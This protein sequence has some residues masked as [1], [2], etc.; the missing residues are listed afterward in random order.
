MATLITCTV[1]P[2]GTGDYDTLFAAIADNFGATSK[3]LVTNDE[4]VKCT[5]ISTNGD[6]DPGAT[7][8][9][10]LSGWSTDATHGVEIE[11][12]EAYR[13]PGVFPETGPY[14]RIDVTGWRGIRVESAYVTIKGLYIRVQISAAFNNYTNGCCLFIKT[15]TGGVRVEDAVYDIHRLDV[16]T[17]PTYGFSGI[18]VEG[19]T[20]SPALYNEFSNIAIRSSQPAAHICQSKGINVNAGIYSMYN[21]FYNVTVVDFWNNWDFSQGSWVLKNILTF[22][23]RSGAVDADYRSDLPAY[24]SGAY[25]SYTQGCNPIT[26]DSNPINLGSDGTAIFLDYTG[27]DLHLKNS[28]SPAYRVG[29]NL[30]SDSDLPITTDFEGDARPASGA[31]SIGA[32]EITA[33][34]SSSTWKGISM[35]FEE[36][37]TEVRHI[38]GRND[39][40]FDHRIGNA[41][42]RAIREWVREFPWQG[43]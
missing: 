24:V 9:L 11:V 35:D 40:M 8:G 14:F 31:H 38:T 29:A 34:V 19:A 25:C 2:G 42:N 15:A 41:V 30:Y 23:G 26:T 10:I 1:D 18:Y 20:G 4:T 22:G 3:A 33:E 7:Y 32:D 6:A 17:Y 12:P 36:I 39:P 27:A 21:R 28:T 37:K 13:P 16:S 43:N 5:C